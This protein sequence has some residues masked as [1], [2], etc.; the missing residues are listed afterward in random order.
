MIQKIGSYQILG[1][2]RAGARPLYKA[3]AADKRIVALKT[4]PVNG[5]TPEERERFLREAQICAG[6]DHPNLMKVEDSGEADGILYQAMDLLEGSDLSNIFGENRLFSWEEKLSIMEQ[7][8][9]GLDYAHQRSLVHRDIKP[10]NI[11][12]ETSGHV[13]VLD[14]GMVKTSSSNLT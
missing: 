4:V 5:V 9:E 7:V 11:F 14:F 10:A 6:L 1:I 12:L 13:R 8:C 2:L 3:E